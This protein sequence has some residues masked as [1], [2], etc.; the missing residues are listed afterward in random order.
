MLFHSLE[1]AVFFLITYSIYLVLPHYWQNRLL[2]VGSY[3]FYG[4]WDWRYLSL[5]LVST[6]VDYFCGQGI[7]KAKNQI[8]KKKFVGISI[9]VNLSILGIFKYY[10]FFAQNFQ[11]LASYFGL[12][13][14]IYLLN[15][16]LPI[17]ISFYT[18]QT[19]SYTIDVFRGKLK[20]AR[21][22]FDFALY[23]SFFPQ[24]IAGPIERGT[25]LLPQILN[26]RGI[27]LEKIYR[28]MYLFLWGLVLKVVL[29]DNLAKIADPVFSFHGPYEGADVL[30]ATYAFSVQ[31]YC[32]F[33]GYSFMAIG[34]G[35]CMG[36]ELM[37]NF[38]R[39]YFSKNISE[40]W[41][42]WHISLSSWFRDYMFSP[43][44]IYLGNWNMF[45]KFS[46]KTRHGIVFLITLLATEF[47]L[48]LWHGAGWNFGFFGIYHAVLIGGYYYTS[49]YWDKLPSPIQIFLTFQL[50]AIGWLVFRATTLS[51]SWDM[52]LSLFHNLNFQLNQ[53]RLEN[54]K[55]LFYYL[56][57]L[58]LIQYF[59]ERKNDTLVILRLP[60]FYRY[61]FISSLL[62]MI[63][64]L[65]DFGGK[66]F[67][68]F[69]F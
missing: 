11:R 23:V 3:I 20:P 52:F 4:S 28:G 24:L 54:V 64:V 57:F 27:T 51:Q 50:A 35:L 59:Q 67:I 2:L 40:F 34:L 30:L 15:A 58:A 25:R 55:Q 60:L 62:L 17:G 13:V 56:F 63:I 43:L 42:R 16:V 6:V 1:F 61:F 5:L 69:Q 22:F 53:L 48:G 10:D 12:E 37:E 46:L 8:A 31:I 36:V 14:D 49:H 44:Y 38:R 45:K 19:M 26:A 7:E 21:N 47:L 33:A 32:D 29:G 68:Y 9:F 39:P 66:P 65:G 41:R 18:F